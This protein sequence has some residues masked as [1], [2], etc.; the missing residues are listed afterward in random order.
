M[1]L[2]NINWVSPPVRYCAKI[3]SRAIH[4]LGSLDQ[5]EQLACIAAILLDRLL[6]Q[7]GD[8]VNGIAGML[9]RMVEGRA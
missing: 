9:T 3:S 1:T 5:F 6:Y 8:P 2:V 4:G 7:T